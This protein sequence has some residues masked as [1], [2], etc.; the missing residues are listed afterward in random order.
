[1][2]SSSTPFLS[3]SKLGP[4]GWCHAHLLWVK[5]WPGTW[6]DSGSRTCGKEEMEA[7]E[8]IEEVLCA[9]LRAKPTSS[10]TCDAIGM[11]FAGAE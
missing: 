9:M 6:L 11:V 1:M 10:D 2:Q 7:R 8:M 3:L 4:G 5:W